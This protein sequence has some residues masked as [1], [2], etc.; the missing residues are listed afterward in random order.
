MKP[1]ALV[2]AAV[3]VSGCVVIDDDHCV[4]TVTLE[5]DFQLTDGAV[6]AGSISQICAAAGV[7]WVDVYMATGAE[8]AQLVD[9]FWCTEGGA[10]VI[11]V[12]QGSYLFTVE[13]VD[14]AGLIRYR[15]EFQVAS[16]CGDQFLATRP[17]AGVVD[18][19]YS[20]PGGLCAIGGTFIHFEIRDEITGTLVPT[21]ASLSPATCPSDIFRAL[22]AGFYTLEWMEERA[23]SS[24]A[25]AVLRRDCTLRQFEIAGGLLTE[26]FP[27]LQTSGVACPHYQ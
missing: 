11:D 21:E 17:A 13:G 24:E 4:G 8:P 15:H 25:S 27:A 20:L 7:T 10:T 14:A 6:P 12:P 26:V 2:L 3:L 23:T 22:P 18:L 5:W 9:R 16:G 1:L 19:N